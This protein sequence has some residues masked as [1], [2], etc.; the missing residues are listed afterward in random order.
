MGAMKVGVVGW[1]S[2]WDEMELEG[3]GTV[4]LERAMTI[5]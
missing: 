4:G 3:R 1:S 2:E 5:M